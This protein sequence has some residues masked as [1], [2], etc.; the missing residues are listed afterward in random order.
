MDLQEF[1]NIELGSLQDLGF[2]DINILEGVDAASSLLDLTANSL[3]NELLDQGQKVH[4]RS[5]T[6]HDL[7]HLLANFPDLACLS[8]GGLL[9]L[10]WSPLGE[11][12]GE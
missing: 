12:N 1:R 9:D 2:A 4:A 7:E 11:G 3:G 6:G 5:L 8:I 10:I